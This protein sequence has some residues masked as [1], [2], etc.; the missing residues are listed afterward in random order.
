MSANISHFAAIFPA[1]VPEQ[2]ATRYKEKPG[3]EITF[4]CANPIEYVVTNRVNK[5][6]IHFVRSGNETIQARQLYVFFEDVDAMHTELVKHGVSE[7]STSE[8]RDYKMRDFD[9]GDPVGNQLTFGSGLT[10]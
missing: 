6:S 8:D 10:A 5:I 7:I 1:K 2:L 3:F 9:I 4:R